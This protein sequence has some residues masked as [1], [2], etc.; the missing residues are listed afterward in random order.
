[1][2]S[3]RVT[4]VVPR[5]GSRRE[6]LARRKPAG[7]RVVHASESWVRDRARDRARN[8]A[9]TTPA[10]PRAGTRRGK[11]ARSRWL[12]E[13]RRVAALAVRTWTGIRTWRTL[14]ASWTDGT[15]TSLSSD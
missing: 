7:R 15:S 11:E 13:R 9:W 10:T 2:G 12:L 3:R 8:R 5:A 4:E 14:G 6:A 1:M